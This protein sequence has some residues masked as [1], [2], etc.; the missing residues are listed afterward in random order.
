MQ[1]TGREG[2]LW[3]SVSGSTVYDWEHIVS[4]AGDRQEAE[5]NA[6][7]AGAQPNFFFQSETLSIESYHLLPPQLT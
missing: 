5:V 6:V 3:F 2:L 1:P 7:N 4:G